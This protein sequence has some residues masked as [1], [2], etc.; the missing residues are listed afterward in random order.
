V[1]LHQAADGLSVAGSECRKDLGMAFD[2]LARIV[3]AISG[4]PV[5][6]ED[7]TPVAGVDAE[8]QVERAERLIRRF[9]SSTTSRTNSATWC[10]TSINGQ[11]RSSC[12]LRR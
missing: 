4:H 5:L 7:Q 11:L 12:T 3:E 10:P 1:L 8:Q 6:A 2:R 9:S